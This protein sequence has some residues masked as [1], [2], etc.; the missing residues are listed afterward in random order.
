VSN[1]TAVFAVELIERI[2]MRPLILM[3]GGF[4]VWAACLG[5]GT[6]MASARATS[7][8]IATTAFVGMWCVAAS[9]DL[10]VG[11]MPAGDSCTEALP[12]VLV[13]C[14]LPVAT[15]AFM[16]WKCCWPWNDR[17]GQEPARSL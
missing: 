1:H 17:N 9:A 5:M 11:V 13:L 4:I 8:T 15:A 10:W 14:G 3:L 16:P 7:M 12:I 2:V 6:R